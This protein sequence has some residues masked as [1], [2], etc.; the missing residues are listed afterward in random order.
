[1]TNALAV[2]AAPGFGYSRVAVGQPGDDA[3]L[4]L[5]RFSTLQSAS[6]EVQSAVQFVDEQLSQLDKYIADLKV[7]WKGDGASAYASK[8]DEW[9]RAARNLNQVLAKVTPALKKA[10]ET[11]TQV[12]Q[13]NKSVWA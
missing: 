8:Q 2:A 4:I 5:V 1:M 6:D 9:N 13:Q 12:E 10:H 11:Y 7:K 3:S